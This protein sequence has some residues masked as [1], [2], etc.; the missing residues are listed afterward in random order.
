M[1]AINKVCKAGTGRV[2][3][4]A[5]GTPVFRNNV[6]ARLSHPCWPKLCGA[7]PAPDRTGLNDTN[8]ISAVPSCRAP[9]RC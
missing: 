1:E 6:I 7:I 3:G 9:T 5:A 2:I 4:M 8:D